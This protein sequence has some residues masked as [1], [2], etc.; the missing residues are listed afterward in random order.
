MSAFRRIAN[1]FRRSR[2]D[3]EIAAEIQAHIDLRTDD[4]VARGMA[5]ADARREA[6]LR[7]GNPDFHART[8]HCSGLEPERR[9]T[10]SRSS[11]HLAATSQISGVRVDRHLHTGHRDW[12]RH[13]RVFGGRGGASAPPAVLPAG[14]TGASARG[15]RTPVRVGRPAGAR[16]DSFFPRKPSLSCRWPA[17]SART[18]S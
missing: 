6:L 17:L 10:R 18:S 9:K 7:F 16:R 12:W 14:A 15:S 4:N 2:L 3:R 13:C 1:L 11:S 8:R 5:P